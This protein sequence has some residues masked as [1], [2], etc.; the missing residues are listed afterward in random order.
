[1]NLFFFAF[2]FTGHKEQTMFKKEIEIDKRFVVAIVIGYNEEDI[3]VAAIDHALAQGMHVFYVDDHSVDA[4][5][6]LVALHFS[7]NDKVGY[8][9][10]PDEFR[11]NKDSEQSWDLGKQLKFKEVLARSTF[12]D[13]EWIVHADCDEFYVCPWAKTVAEGLQNVPADCGI[14]NCTVRDHFPSAK[15]IG[16]WK[17]EANETPMRNIRQLVTVYRQRVDY[18]YHRF[19]RNHAS[20][21]L[22]L[23]HRATTEPARRFEKNMIMLHYPYRS[24]ALAA[25]KL[26]QN[27]LPRIS[28]TDSEK[29]VGFHYKQDSKT[30]QLPLDAVMR[31]ANR[32]IAN[33]RAAWLKHCTWYLEEK[34]DKIPIFIISHNRLTVLKRCIASIKACFDERY[35]EIVIHDNISTYAPLITFLKESGLKVYWNKGNELDDVAKSVEHYFANNTDND[36]RFYAVTD[37]D[38][39]FDVKQ[40]RPDTLLFYCHLLDNV[41]KIDSVGPELRV[42]DIPD[43]YPLKQELLRLH[44]QGHANDK[45]LNVVWQDE[46]V[47]CAFRKLDTTFGLYRRS[48]RFK[49]LNDALLCHGRHNAR[50]LDWYLDPNNMSEDDLLYMQNTS[51][52]GHWSSTMLK[53]KLTATQ[54]KQ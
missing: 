11:A 6:N 36:S 8:T 26:S 9:V 49:R 33:N 32:T 40:T 15:D 30:L 24:A 7:N 2:V 3:I 38:I 20:L 16:Q 53:P 19:L 10:L 48:F 25:H 5:R 43:H 50:H 14:V 46:T 17:L 47:P 51:R 29:N 27:R 1:M 31:Q 22:N 21:K 37:P 13:Y 41:Q 44:R 42:D 34:V 4:T 39:E 54:E 35:Y 45:F 52:W 12:I 18:F 23:G 28:S